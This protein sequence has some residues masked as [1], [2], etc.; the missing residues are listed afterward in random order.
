MSESIWKSSY[1]SE[2]GTKRC[3]RAESNRFNQK[4]GMNVLE[5]GVNKGVVAQRRMLKRN[6]S[7]IIRIHI[8]EIYKDNPFLLNSYTLTQ[9]DERT[10]YRKS[11]KK[12]PTFHSLFPR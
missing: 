11:P 7:K 3:Y 8:G 4:K 12:K 5:S 2:R 9:T 10:I 6:D 1:K